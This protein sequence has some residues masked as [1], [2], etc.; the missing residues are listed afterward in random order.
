MRHKLARS[1][2]AGVV[3]VAVLAILT[4][5]IAASGASSPPRTHLR[6]RI[7]TAP[8]F[9]SVVP[10]V[11]RLT[12]SW[13]PPSNVLGAAVRYT[14]RSVPAGRRCSTTTTSCT[15]RHVDDATR[16]R[17]RVTAATSSGRG[18]ASRLTAPPPQMTVLV[19]AGQSNAVGIDAFAID[20][21][22]HHDVLSSARIDEAAGS[23]LSIWRESGVP[24]AGPPPV[25]L[26]TPQALVD[27][28]SPVFGPEMGLVTRLYEDGWRNLL[29]VKVAFAGT[30]LA[31]DWTTSGILYQTLIKTTQG[32]LSWA[33]ANGWSATVGGVYWLQGETD[34]EHHH[35]ALAYGQHLTAFIASVRSDLALNARTP[36]VLGEIDVRKYIGYRLSHHLCTWR[37]CQAELKGNAEVRAAQ[38]LV[39]S[40]V[41]ST[42]LVDTAPLARYGD[43]FIHLTNLA[44]LRLGKEFAIASV[45]HLT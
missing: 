34:A 23:T 32:A 5:A 39:A 3:V 30:S 9:V 16:W 18:P 36:F 45:H 26:T 38:R 31:D 13:A 15:F 4:V 12:V 25:P 7:P 6:P 11:G 21:T 14:V 42:Y 35:M 40:T 22:T 43:V 29:V 28:P 24:D 20:P 44:E 1:T 37:A 2:G 33:A 10:G 17:F 27:A 41:P 8:L 19:V